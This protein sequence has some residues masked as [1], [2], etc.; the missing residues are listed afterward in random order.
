M[1]SAL[2]HPTYTKDFL[3]ESFL[4]REWWSGEAAPPFMLEIQSTDARAVVA[5]QI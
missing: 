4:L 1:G 3:H 2:L 5:Q